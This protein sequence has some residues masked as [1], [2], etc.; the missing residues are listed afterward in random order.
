MIPVS[1]L[2]ELFDKIEKIEEYIL[3]STNTSFP[4]GARWVSTKQA[5]SLLAID[6][7]SWRKYRRTY[8]FKVTKI[9]NKQ[10]VDLD[11]IQQVMEQNII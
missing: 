7:K 10:Y 8:A 11:S 5:I 3:H 9:G 2:I 4:F 1:Q 6:E